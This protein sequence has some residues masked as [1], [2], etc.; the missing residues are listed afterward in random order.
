MGHRPHLAPT[1]DWQQIGLLVR[2]PEERTY[3]L[4]RPSTRFL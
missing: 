3:E 1:D 4:I 2:F